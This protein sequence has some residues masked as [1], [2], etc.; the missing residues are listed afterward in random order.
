MSSKVF[1]CS[2]GARTTEPY[3]VKGIAMCILCAQEAAPNIVE[4]RVRSEERRYR[5]TERHDHLM[6]RWD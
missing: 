2:C 3:M 4:R 6:R 1:H 5:N